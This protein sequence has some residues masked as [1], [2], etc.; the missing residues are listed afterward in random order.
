MG[1]TGSGKS[2]FIS[3]LTGKSDHVVGHGLSSSALT[4]LLSTFEKTY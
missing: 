3:L 1:L 2:T 4:Y